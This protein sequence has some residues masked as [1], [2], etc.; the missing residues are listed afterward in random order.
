MIGYP[1]DIRMEAVKILRQW[2]DEGVL[3][4]QP[5]G[6]V[7][8]GNYK[9]VKQTIFTSL[10]IQAIFSFLRSFIFIIIAIML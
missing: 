1:V 7:V 8:L 2:L 4:L 3:V 10:E 6:E 9:K 5:N